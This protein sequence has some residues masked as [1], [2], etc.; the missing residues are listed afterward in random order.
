MKN[1]NLLENRKILQF[2]SNK[3]LPVT[4][5]LKKK[6][7]KCEQIKSLARNL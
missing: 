3:T 1:Y 6:E 4:Y 5:K 2:F 7:L